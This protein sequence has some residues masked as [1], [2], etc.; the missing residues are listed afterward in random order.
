[1]NANSEHLEALRGKRLAFIG[2]G[3]MAEAIIATLLRGELVTPAQIVGAEPHA[4]RRADLT[5]RYGFETL[6]DNRAGLRKT[7][8]CRR[9]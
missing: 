4:E 8:S 7:W 3:V 6:A 5:G 2:C 9:C 1:M